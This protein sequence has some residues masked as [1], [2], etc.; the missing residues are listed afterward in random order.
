M[1]AGDFQGASELLGFL[2]MQGG[3]GEAFWRDYAFCLYQAQ[4]YKEAERATGQMLKKHFAVGFAYYLRHFIALHDQKP[5]EA[6]ELLEKALTTEPDNRAFR[7][8][9][10]RFQQA[11]TGD[12]RARS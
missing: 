4:R 3:A 10:H 7:D 6:K 5:G 8:A 12:S 11:S 2:T 1:A 9:W